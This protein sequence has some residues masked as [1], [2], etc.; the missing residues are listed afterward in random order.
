MPSKALNLSAYL[1]LARGLLS[2]GQF[3]E[4]LQTAEQGIAEY[5]DDTALLGVAAAA[6]HA[7]GHLTGSEAY[8]RRLLHINPK[9]MTAHSSLGWLLIE[10]KRFDEARTV[11]ANALVVDPCNTEVIENLAFLLH[12]TGDQEGARRLGDDWVK[13]RP[14]DARALFSRLP[15]ALPVVP[16]SELDSRR[17]TVEFDSA[18]ACFQAAA[19]RPEM[20]DSVSNEIARRHLF[21]LAYRYGNHRDRLCRYGNLVARLLQTRSDSVHAA[22]II[23]LAKRVRIAIVSEHVSGHPVFVILLHGMLQHIDRERF[24]VIMINQGKENDAATSI[25]RAQATRYYGDISSWQRV[26][27]ILRIERPNVIFYP[28]IGMNPDTYKLASLRF[29]P[30]Q[31]AS[32][33][34]PITTGLP[35][36]DMFLSGELLEGQDAASHYCERLIKLPGTGAC[37]LSRPVQAKSIDHL[38]PEITA[39]RERGKTHFVLCQSP[40]KFDPGDDNLYARIA[41]QAGACKF[42]LVCHPDRQELNAILL[43]RLAGVFRNYGLDPNDY[44]GVVPWLAEAEFYTL[45]DNMDVY[46]DCPAFSG[47]TTAWQAL[48]RGLPIVTLE[49]EFL[50]QRLAAG[51]LRQ[52]GVIDGIASNA[53]EFVAKAV[54]LAR[55]P[56]SRRAM[57]NRL[58]V[59]AAG[60]DN[61]T[62]VVRALEGHLLS[63][64]GRNC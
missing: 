1:N 16:R 64:V 8:L 52:A 21:Y 46:L 19:E 56:E 40:F 9:L 61:R 38:S 10:M 7:S 11:L 53:D 45:L 57:R 44:L 43:S 26:V 35:T 42:W 60:V 28:E 14:D 17:A 34:H 22:S 59:A 23:E 13:R 58:S 12:E 55:N 54:A 6:S 27:D 62:E 51:L 36:I 31:V 29:A 24:E 48:H 3:V 20:L 18:L 41:E 63:A 4:A 50:R 33:G 49:G 5:S 32:W 2:S 15:L 39:K 47:Y 30:L 25:A 37:T